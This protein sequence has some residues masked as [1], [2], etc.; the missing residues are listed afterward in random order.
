VTR[1]ECQRCHAICFTTDPPHLCADLRKRLERQ[2][3]AVAIVV[4]IL[5]PGSEDQALEIVKA[6]SGRDLG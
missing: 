6:L 3:K 5:G 1:Y 2:E 4:A